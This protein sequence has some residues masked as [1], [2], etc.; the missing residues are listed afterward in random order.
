MTLDPKA[1]LISIFDAAV[2]AADPLRT[3]ERHLPPKPKGRTVVIG[4]G[5]GAAQMAQAFE[6]VW[7]APMRAL[8]LPVTAMPR[9]LQA[10]RSAG[11]LA[12]GSRRGR[13]E[14]AKRL[15]DLVSGLTPDD[16]VIALVCGGGSALLPAPA[17][18]LDLGRRDGG[19][20][21]A[22]RLRRADLG[23]EL[24]AQACLQYQ[25]RPA[26]GA[27]AS[28]TGRVAGGLRYPRRQSGAGGFGPDRPGRHD[29]RRMRSTSSRP[30]A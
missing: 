28:C 26:G 6:Q 1:F 22:A 15:T 21:G 2:A 23:D 27:C 3:I 9:R 13:L 4:F 18:D 14:G 5:K 17:G 16:L 10:Y 11:G 24:R 12:S 30:T 8:S 7:D 29:A 19:Q 20:R 25:G